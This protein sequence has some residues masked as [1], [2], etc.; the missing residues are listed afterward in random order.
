MKLDGVGQ[1]FGEGE[2]EGEVTAFGDFMC[3][4]EGNLSVSLEEIPMTTCTPLELQS[5]DSGFR[6]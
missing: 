2:I 6:Y 5:F 3:D 1:L 4:G